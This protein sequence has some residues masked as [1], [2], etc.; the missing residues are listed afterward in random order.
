MRANICFQYTGG[1]SFHLL[2]EDCKTP[3]TRWRRIESEEALLGM[4]AK[5]RGDVAGAKADIRRWSRGGVR[6]E[7]SPAQCEFFR[8]QE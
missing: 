7:L 5:M 8:I 4:I 2:S 6:V 3:L 1:W